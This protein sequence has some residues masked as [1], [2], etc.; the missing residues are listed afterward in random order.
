MVS[1]L[2]GEQ[3]RSFEQLFDDAKQQGFTKQGEMFSGTTLY[4]WYK[5]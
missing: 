1:Q 2:V 3:E 4:C 5:I